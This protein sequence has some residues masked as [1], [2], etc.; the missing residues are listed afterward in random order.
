M[1]AQYSLRRSG[2]QARICSPQ[3]VR[4]PDRLPI[5]G[6]LRHNLRD[7]A[8]PCARDRLVATSCGE[9][10]H[11]GAM[12]GGGM[13]ILVV[14]DDTVLAAALTRAMTQAAYTVDLVESGEDAN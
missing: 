5:R 7:N 13:R 8:R 12:V 4:P 6:C 1:G 3:P 9:A 11:D 2:A 10:V 14:E